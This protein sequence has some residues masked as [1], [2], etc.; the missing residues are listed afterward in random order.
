[1]YKVNAEYGFTQVCDEAISIYKDK[2]CKKLI[3]IHDI[4][5]RPTRKY[6]LEEYDETKEYIEKVKTFLEENKILYNYRYP[7]D[8]KDR[9]FNHVKK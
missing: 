8:F 2:K 4:Y 9:L 3:G 1:M 6:I 5:T 7:I